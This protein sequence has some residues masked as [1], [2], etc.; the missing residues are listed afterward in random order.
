[1]SVACVRGPVDGGERGG[2]MR[3]V[4]G[5]RSEGSMLQW[6]LKAST[7]EIRAVLGEARRDGDRLLVMVCE[8]EL[9]RRGQS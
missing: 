5:T 4:F 8:A 6:A 2:G 1:M 9:Q 3:E 7:G